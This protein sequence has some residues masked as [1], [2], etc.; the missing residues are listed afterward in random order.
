MGPAKS[1][2]EKLLLRTQRKT[3]EPTEATSR[4]IPSLRIPE[5]VLHAKCQPPLQKR[6]HSD[7][8]CRC[9]LAR[10]IQVWAQAAIYDSTFIVFHCGNFER[11]GIRDRKNQTLHLSDV[12]GVAHYQDLAYGKI[13][14][15]VYIAI[16]QDAIV[17]KKYI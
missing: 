1:A 13:K 2:W 5:E 8:S 11:I 16:L 4:V 10:N 17:G 3:N 12:I 7:L 14:L 9:H 6:K 15:G